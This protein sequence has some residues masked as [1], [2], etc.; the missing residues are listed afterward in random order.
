MTK[1][2]K[3]NKGNVHSLL[4]TADTFSREKQGK[5][6]SVGKSRRTQ[7][8]WEEQEKLERDVGIIDIPRK[9]KKGHGNSNSR[10]GKE[11]ITARSH[12]F[13]SL[14]THQPSQLLTAELAQKD[15]SPGHSQVFQPAGNWTHPTDQKGAIGLEVMGKFIVRI[16]K[17]VRWRKNPIPIHLS[18]PHYH[19]CIPSLLFLVP[20]PIPVF[21][22]SAIPLF[23]SLFLFPQFP[24]YLTPT[25]SNEGI[26]RMALEDNERLKGGSLWNAAELPA[27]QPV[28][29]CY[30]IRRTREESRPPRGG[31]P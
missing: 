7:A 21:P 10:V 16:T 22:I 15:I 3:V 18:F 13:W 20:P 6:Q 14:P 4:W 19:P 11:A 25:C 2:N 26:P 28:G 5:W 8:L 1:R 24:Q 9:E 23:I 12:R 29:E 27:W 31:S 30:R 17:M